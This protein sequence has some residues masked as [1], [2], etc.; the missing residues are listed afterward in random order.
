MMALLLKLMFMDHQLLVRVD[1]ELLM[2]LVLQ[3]VLKDLRSDQMEKLVLVTSGVNNAFY[4]TA[5]QVLTSGGTGAGV[6]WSDASSGCW[7]FNRYRFLKE[8]SD[9]CR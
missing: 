5:G 4:G 8:F 1:L 2:L 9:F 3:V 7:N 6:T